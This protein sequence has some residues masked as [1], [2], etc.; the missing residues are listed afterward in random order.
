MSFTSKEDG[1]SEDTADWMRFLQSTTKDELF[2]RRDTLALGGD[3]CLQVEFPCEWLLWIEG[4]FVQPY[5]LESVMSK[6]N[7]STDQ[8]MIALT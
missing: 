7:L 3:D 5:S 2:Q 8:T 1:H 6:K 4:G